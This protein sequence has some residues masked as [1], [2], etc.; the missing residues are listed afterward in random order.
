VLHLHDKYCDG[1]TQGLALLGHLS[2]REAIIIVDAL[3]MGAAPGT[4]KIL[5]FSEVSRMGASRANTSHEG[6]AGE[7]LAIAKVLD[8]LPDR[9]FIVGVEPESVATGYGLSE[10]VRKA[11]PIAAARLRYLLAECDCAI[12]PQL[13]SEI[14]TVD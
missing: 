4:T 8:E 14:S 11:L 6:N 2:G 5:D 12:S 7:L 10:S 3:A 1:G 13:P 9:V